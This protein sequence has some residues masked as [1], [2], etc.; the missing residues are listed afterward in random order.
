M[1]AKLIS[2]KIGPFQVYPDMSC[3]SIYNCTTEAEQPGPLWPP[4][5]LQQATITAAFTSLRIPRLHLPQVSPAFCRVLLSGLA[6]LRSGRTLETIQSSRAFSTCCSGPCGH[7]NCSLLSFRG[8]C[9]GRNQTVA[10]SSSPPSEQAAECQQCTDG[11][12]FRV[13]SGEEREAGST[14]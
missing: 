13:L 8:K 2:S 1:L 14:S 10:T 5:S 6:H 12:D 7:W 9:G 11:T 3:F 4:T